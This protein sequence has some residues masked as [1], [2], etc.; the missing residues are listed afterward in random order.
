MISIKDA[1][2]NLLRCSN[3]VVG[4]DIR[5]PDAAEAFDMLDQAR[6]LARK[7]LTT[8]A[9]GRDELRERIALILFNDRVQRDGSEP[10]TMETVRAARKR[11]FDI[12]S[13][14]KPLADAI[15]SALP[16]AP[17]VDEAG[18][19]ADASTRLSDLKTSPELLELIERAK[20]H[21]MTPE[22]I[23]EQ[24]R[25]FARGMCPSY[26]DYKEW[27][28]QIDRLMP[29]LAQAIRAGGCER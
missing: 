20:N 8:T 12:L 28:E 19:R 24:R 1:L 15:L 14:H 29:P 6:I 17:V 13:H 10:H 2:E 25:S 23:Y 27:C 11:G 21:V 5:D 16:V 7:A 26:R 22:E 4:A 18:I 9:P 3:A